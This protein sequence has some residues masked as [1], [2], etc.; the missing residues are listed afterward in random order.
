MA[1]TV[2]I[3]FQD[4]KEET[5]NEILEMAQEEIREDENLM[6]EIKEMYPDS[7]DEI[8]AERAERRLYQFDYVFNV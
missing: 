8:V 2:Y 1:R 4:L 7:I 3:N 6:A 5:Q